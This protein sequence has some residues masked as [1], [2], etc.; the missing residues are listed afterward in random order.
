[1]N[2]VESSNCRVKL[3]D[4]AFFAFV[5]V[6]LAGDFLADATFFSGDDSFD[7]VVAFTP[8]FGEAFF[9]G[10][11]ALEG[12]AFF[13]TLP[14]CTRSAAASCA[15]AEGTVFLGELLVVR[16]GMAVLDFAGLAGDALVDLAGEALRPVFAGVPSA[17]DFAMA[18]I[19]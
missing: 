17:R 1:M 14:V 11:V 6:D 13:A 4:A 18:D 5:G 7:G 15:F 9:A 19:I 10:V 2:P 12:E 16:S 8:F 3:D